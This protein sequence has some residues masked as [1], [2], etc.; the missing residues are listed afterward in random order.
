[1]KNKIYSV[2][3]CRWGDRDTHSYMVG[4]YSKKSKA[5]KAA[6]IEEDYR[7]GKYECEIQEWNI[8]KGLEGKMFNDIGM[9]IIKPLPKINTLEK[10]N[11]KPKPTN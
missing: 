2:R 3:A 9:K 4:V 8:D 5:L 1:M 6:E 7:G 10:R 11:P